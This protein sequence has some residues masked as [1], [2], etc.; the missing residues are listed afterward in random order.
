L[1][2]PE[3]DSLEAIA[4]ELVSSRIAER[5]ALQHAPTIDSWVVY[6]H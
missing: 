6:V 2:Q 5:V 4:T 3:N 1:V